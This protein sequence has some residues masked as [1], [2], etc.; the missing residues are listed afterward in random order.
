M[1]LRRT[2]WLLFFLITVLLSSWKKE[3]PG[4]VTDY[5]NLID[6]VVAELDSSIFYL[7][8]LE[9][10]H[11]GEKGIAHYH[12]SRKHYKHIE[13]FVEVVSPK[14]AK[15]YV[16]GPLII[17]Y[18]E[19]AEGYMVEPHGFQVMEEFLFG[20]EGDKEYF[21]SELKLLLERLTHLKNTYTQVSLADNLFL[22]MC[23]LELF[24]ISS[25]NLN[26]YDASIEKTSITESVWCFEGMERVLEYY[27]AKYLGT[28]DTQSYRKCFKTISK[29]KDY[30]NGN[31]DYDS[32]DRL[33]FI[34]RFIQPLNNELIDLHVA[35][36]LPWSDAKLPVRLN[37][38]GM[39]SE[40]T[41]DPQYFS[42]YYSD[43]TGISLQAELGKILFYDPILSDN[44]KRA[45]SSCHKPDKAFTDGLKRAITFDG[46]GITDRNAPSLIDV[47]FF[48]S[49]FHDGRAYQLEQQA[50]DVLR[51]H[52]E[53][54]SSM[55]EIVNK[56]RSS[57]QYKDLFGKAFKRERDA[58]ISSYAVLKA[59]V[60]YEKTLISF[61][62]RFDQYLAGDKKA[63][64]KDEI[65]GYNLFAGKALCGSC[66][67]FPVFNGTVPPVY[68]ESEFE[69][70]GTPL[71]DQNKKLDE[72][73]GR[74]N[75]TY[76]PIHD[77]SFKTPTVRNSE[78]TAPYMHN[79]IYSKLEDVVTFYQK[80]GG[81]GLGFDVPNQTLPFDSLQLTK[82]EEQQI[83]LFMKSLTDTS[84]LQVK[85]FPLPQFESRLEWNDRRWGGEY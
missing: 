60:E 44:N 45:C 48:K 63:L 53:M 58:V 10:R 59:L 22:E 80:G 52:L 82:K 4:E 85:P 41:F 62:S 56:L 25:L 38:Y 65:T 27:S 46:K 72:D 18:S 31:K 84:G 33:A 36:N 21:Q 19:Y 79:G 61:Q 57:Q 23:Q 67:F 50:S 43:T 26:G 35:L 1:V 30:L 55:E 16:N 15:Y 12:N 17:K 9:K 81:A 7:Q 78:L 34:T 49:F 66:H 47:V 6:Y 28:G 75:V 11:S 5:A 13:W 42:I 40:Q 37:Q 3:Q 39:F 73:R 24:R 32:F 68:F 54:N 29:A 71:N 74:W 20:E 70:L 69:V 14:D 64:T 2:Y 77:R 83:I 76:L 8:E 51:N